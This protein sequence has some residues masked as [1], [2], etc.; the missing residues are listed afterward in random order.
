MIQVSK[1]TVMPTSLC[2]LRVAL[3][4]SGSTARCA[5]GMRLIINSVV[6]IMTC[7]DLDAIPP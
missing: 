6:M 4:I 5:V 1:V 3:P 7:T 2:V